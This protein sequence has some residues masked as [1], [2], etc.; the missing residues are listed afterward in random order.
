MARLLLSALSVTATNLLAHA[1]NVV[2]SPFSIQV[3]RR[4]NP[5]K[6]QMP[7]DRKFAAWIAEASKR[8][9]D[10][11]DLGDVAWSDDRLEESL[12]LHYLPHITPTSVVLEL[13]PGTGRLT[14]HVIGRCGELL[15]A[16]YS[17]LVCDWLEHYLQSKGKFRIVRLSGPLL[18]ELADGTVDVG[19][20]HG[21]FEHIDLDDMAWFLDEFHRVLRP[22]GVLV[23][24]FDNI[25]SRGGQEWFLRWRPAPGGRGI[26][27]FYHPEVVR[28]AAVA[29]GFDV[30]RLTTDDSRLATATLRKQ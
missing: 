4:R 10:P 28:A 24:N 6:G 26:F 27:R 23:F 9:I 11:N 18:T 14:R 25:V 15:L 13:G 21:V 22:G 5:A 29:S 17:P 30:E 2:L 7:W 19:L 20:A 12:P 1:A 3:V 8:G 16:D